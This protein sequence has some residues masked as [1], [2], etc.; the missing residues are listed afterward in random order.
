MVFL[1]NAPIVEISIIGNYAKRSPHQDVAAPYFLGVRNLVTGSLAYLSDNTIDDGA[2]TPPITPFIIIASEGIDPRTG[3]PP[4]TAPSGYTPLSS[5]ATYAHV[6]LNAGAR[7]ANRDD[8]DA[9][10]IADVEARSGDLISDPA[11]VGGYPTLAENTST[12]TQVANPHADADSDGY[13]NFE[14]QL[15]GYA[16]TVE[17]APPA[18]QGPLRFRLTVK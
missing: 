18:S 9:R 4:I 2:I 5:A 1:G 8:V 13:T 7:P 3:T 6:L 11:T 17:G 12:F 14:E 15:H 10:I 16:A